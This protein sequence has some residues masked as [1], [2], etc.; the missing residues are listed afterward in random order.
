MPHN[1]A[2]DQSLDCLLTEYPIKIQTK[3]KN[4]TQHPLK[5][6]WTVQIGDG[7]KFQMG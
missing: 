1:A 7:G 5:Q 4:T 6:K 2:S 3:M